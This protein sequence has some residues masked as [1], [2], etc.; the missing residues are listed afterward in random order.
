MPA[1]VAHTCNPSYSGGRDQ[2]DYSSKPAQANISRD[3]ISKIP[4]ANRAGGVAQGVSPAFKPWYHKN[5]TK[6]K[7]KY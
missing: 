2:D 1:P 7:A 3:P 5:K 6:T 4:N